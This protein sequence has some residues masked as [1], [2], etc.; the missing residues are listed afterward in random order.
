VHV[1]IPL[2]LALAIAVVVAAVSHWSGRSNPPWTHV[3]E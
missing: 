2:V 1:P 3:E